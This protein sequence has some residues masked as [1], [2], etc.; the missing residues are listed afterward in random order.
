MNTQT[1]WMRPG[2]PREAAVRFKAC[3][4]KD[5]SPGALPRPVNMGSAGLTHCLPVGLVQAGLCAVASSRP[6]AGTET[7][8]K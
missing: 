7:V 1:V 8:A 4:S 2:P 5:G 6:T 3:H